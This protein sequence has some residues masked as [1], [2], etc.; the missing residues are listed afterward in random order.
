MQDFV[1]NISLSNINGA[2]LITDENPYTGREQRGIFLPLDEANI[3]ISEKNYCYI[4]FYAM[5]LDKP[6][7]KRT[8]VLK[9]IYDKE[10]LNFIINSGMVKSRYIGKLFP[11]SERKY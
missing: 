4:S 10:R 6:L 11:V 5:H 1:I 9:P 7:P 2:R 8:H 3:H